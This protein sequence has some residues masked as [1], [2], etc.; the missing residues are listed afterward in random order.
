MIC[1]GIIVIRGEEP[2][3]SVEGKGSHGCSPLIHTSA[4]H[5]PPHQEAGRQIQLCASNASHGHSCTVHPCPPRLARATDGYPQARVTI[6]NRAHVPLPPRRPAPLSVAGPLAVDLL[7]AALERCAECPDARPFRESVATHR[8]RRARE[9]E[10]AHETR[11]VAR[12]YASHCCRKCTHANG[13]GIYH[14]T[15]CTALCC[16][17]TIRTFTVIS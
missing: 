4:V 16:I 17:E 6:P 2:W 10:Q 15:A 8:H 14:I 11:L 9:K 12:V 3:H 13:R 7:R 1:T 5:L